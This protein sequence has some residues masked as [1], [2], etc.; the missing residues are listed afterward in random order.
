MPLGQVGQQIVD[1][2]EVSGI[3]DRPCNPGR[4]RQ[5]DRHREPLPFSGRSS[6]RAQT[7]GTLAPGS[8]LAVIPTLS[9]LQR[10]RGIAALTAGHDQQRLVVGLDQI[11]PGHRPHVTHLGIS[12]AAIVDRGTTTRRQPLPRLHPDPT[13][14]GHHIQQL[15]QICRVP[16]WVPNSPCLTGPS[17]TDRTDRRTKPLVDGLDGTGWKLLSG[18]LIR[19]FWV[20]V[21]GGVR[22]WGAERSTWSFEPRSKPPWAPNSEFAPRPR[23]VYL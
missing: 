7:R 22:V 23:G 20:Q 4:R 12:H 13:D 5:P 2:R 6:D 18:L 17:R 8:T 16:K 14:R 11:R 1:C 19:R 10:H 3:E 15:V 9:I 21:P